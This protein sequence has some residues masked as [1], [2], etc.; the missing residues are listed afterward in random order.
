M[1]FLFTSSNNLTARI[2]RTAKTLSIIS[3]PLTTLFGGGK[4]SRTLDPLLAK[5][6]L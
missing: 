4:E 3:T 2:S 5:Q 1:H 6:V